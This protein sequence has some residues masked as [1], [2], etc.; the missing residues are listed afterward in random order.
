M[1][2]QLVG[3]SGRPAKELSAGQVRN[4]TNACASAGAS[5]RRAKEL[6]AGQV[7]VHGCGQGRRSHRLVSLF[8]KEAR[9]HFVESRFQLWIRQSESPEGRR[10]KL[11]PLQG[12]QVAS[13]KVQPEA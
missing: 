8:I 12:V 1:P 4:S 13:G 10:V 3:H 9:M 7:S 2:E 5:R 6:S 11:V